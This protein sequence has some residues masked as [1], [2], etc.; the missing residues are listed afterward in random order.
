MKWPTRRNRKKQEAIAY[1][2]CGFIIAIIS[3]GTY[4]ILLFSGME[5]QDANLISLV[6]GKSAAYIGNKKYVFKSECDN[7]F[8]EIKEIFRFIAARGA[9]MLLD[10]YG[11]IFVVDVL[12]WDE[13]ISK[14]I[15][16]IIVVALNFILSRVLVFR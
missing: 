5:Y 10:Y 3:I 16:V 15:I 7:I 4:Q 2:V 14:I 6:I 12:S 1:I 11:L 8:A 13:S 9:T